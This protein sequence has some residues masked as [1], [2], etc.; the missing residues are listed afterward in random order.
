VVRV[1][2]RGG[3]AAAPAG[4]HAAAAR[5]RRSPMRTAH[6]LLLSVAQHSGVSRQCSQLAGSA[7]LKK[8]RDR[9]LDIITDSWFQLYM[10]VPAG[11]STVLQQRQWQENFFTQTLHT[12]QPPE[13]TVTHCNTAFTISH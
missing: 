7:F 11:R 8:R 6:N 1:L 5:A 2:R 3:F 13:K 9:T 12:L 10:H 4:Q